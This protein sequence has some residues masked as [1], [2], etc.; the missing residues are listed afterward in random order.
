MTPEVSAPKRAD[1]PRGEPPRVEPPAPAGDPLS[2]L[3]AI[4]LGRERD[5]IRRIEQKLDDPEALSPVVEKALTASVRRDPKPLADALFPVMGPAIRRAISQALAGMMQSVNQALEHTFSLQ[6]LAWRWEAIRT[7]TSFA[8]VVLRHSL[9]YR[10]EQVFLVHRE[11]GLLLQHVTAPTI[12]AQ[13]PDMVAGML[14]AIQDFTRDSFGVAQ[15]EMLETMQVGELTVWVEQGARTLLAAVIRGHAPFEF[16]RE[17]QRALEAVEGEHAAELVKFQGDAAPFARSRP[18]LDA[19]LLMEAR[20][21]ERKPPWR[22]YGLLAVAL[23]L[24]GVLLVPRFVGNHRWNAYLDRLRDE[25]GV[26]VTDAGRQGGHFVVRGLRDPLA[27]DPMALLAEQKL[28]TADVVGRWEPYVA[29]LPQFILSRATRALAPPPTIGL[30]LVADTLIAVGVATDAWFA[31][32]GTLAPAL[33]GVGSFSVEH[34][35]PRELPQV[36]PLVAAIENRRILF[37]TAVASLDSASG[38]DAEVLVADIARLD[39]VARTLGLTLRLTVV[40]SADDQGNADANERLRI[41]RA[42]ALRARIAPILPP[43]LVAGTEL[44]AVDATPAA[45]DEERARR[46]AAMVRVDPALATEPVA[47]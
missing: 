9:L 3:R 31:R 8:E 39:S 1:P 29:L 32:A 12:A 23:I 13:P 2:R 43:G 30:H 26:I 17:L 22:T 4:L 11:S 41:D 14:T 37:P 7:G 6:G 44:A 25:P 46:R 33:A 40:G 16:R 15:E 27:R 35:Q 21:P 20:D 38:A 19:L 10:V 5:Q 18:R 42:E 34:L 24:L 47:P 36:K 45:T 28:A